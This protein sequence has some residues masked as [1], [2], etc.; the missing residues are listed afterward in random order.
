MSDKHEDQLIGK[1]LFKHYKLKKKIG[2]QP[3]NVDEIIKKEENT[4]EFYDFVKKCLEIDPE[5]RPS[6]KELI[7][8]EFI[9]K[10]AKDNNIIKETKY[11][12]PDL[13]ISCNLLTHIEMVGIIITRVINKETALDALSTST[14]A[15]PTTRPTINPRIPEI[16][17]NLI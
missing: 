9:V 12:N 3:P 5:K 15:L 10:Y 7:K 6:A 4:E 2:N 14:P 13:L 16:I 17:L 1:I 11:H 8:H